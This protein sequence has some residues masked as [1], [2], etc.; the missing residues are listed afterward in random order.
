[1]LSCGSITLFI[2]SSSFINF[3]DFSTVQVASAETGAIA[4]ACGYSH[5]LFLTKTG[6]VRM[7]RSL[8]PRLFWMKKT[9]CLCISIS[10]SSNH[11]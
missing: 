3:Q 4:V 7:K 2:L 9:V 6:E 1:M 11:L 8:K 5:S 10:M